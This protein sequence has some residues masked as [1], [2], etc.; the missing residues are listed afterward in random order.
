MPLRKVCVVIPAYNAERTLSPLLV[1]LKRTL[2]EATILVVNDG[3]VDNTHE[4]A[5]AEDIVY[6]KH[7]SNRGKGAALKTGFAHALNLGADLIATMDADLQH[8]VGDLRGLLEK[9]ENDNLDLVIGARMWDLASMPIHRRISN[10]TTSQLLSWRLQQKISDSQC[11]LRVH[12]ARLL[13]EISVWSN[14]FDFESELLLKAGLGGFRIGFVNI[15]T[16]YHRESKSSMRWFDTLRFIKVY[17]TSFFG[18]KQGR[19]DL[20][21]TFRLT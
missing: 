5:A 17:C 7:H 4:I 14:H 1:N 9:I 3:S 15:R 13:R 8:D 6:L 19:T 20:R 21:R 18:W 16:I 2:P 11:G 12:R 10:K